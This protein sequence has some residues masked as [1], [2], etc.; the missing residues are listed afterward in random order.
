M[1]AK[2]Q[3]APNEHIDIEPTSGNPRLRERGIKV[4]FLKGYLNHP[5]HTVESICEMHEITP[6][7]L[8]AAWAYYLTKLC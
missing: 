5:E 1:I 3:L 2:N 7:Q 8:Y 4:E 6:A